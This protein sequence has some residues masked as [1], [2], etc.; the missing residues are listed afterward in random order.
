M[1]IKKF[2]QFNESVDSQNVPKSELILNPLSYLLEISIVS[3]GNSVDNLLHGIYVDLKIET[4]DISVDYDQRMDIYIEDISKTL[5]YLILNNFTKESL[6]EIPSAFYNSDF[7]MKTFLSLTNE[8]N[9]VKEGDEII[10]INSVYKI[11]RGIAHKGLSGNLII[12]LEGYNKIND[13]IFIV[14]TE[15]YNDF[16]DDAKYY[17]KPLE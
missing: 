14:K 10:M 6:L 2:K 9:D 12:E 5:S 3:L 16:I 4:G 15:T 8:S 17:L 7:D 13:A 1:K 11:I